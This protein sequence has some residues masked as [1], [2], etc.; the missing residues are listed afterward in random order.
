MTEL[1]E[2]LFHLITALYPPLQAI[3]LGL[4]IV[5][6]GFCSYV[7]FDIG[8]VGGGVIFAVFALVCLALLIAGLAGGWFRPRRGRRDGKK[9]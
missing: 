1:L 8:S 9:K 2:L 6:F 4:G 5:L 7:F 3:L